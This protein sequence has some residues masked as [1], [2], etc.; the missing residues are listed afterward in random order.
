MNTN[1]LSELLKKFKSKPNFKFYKKSIDTL[2]K[3]TPQ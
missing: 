1:V 2:M 3:C